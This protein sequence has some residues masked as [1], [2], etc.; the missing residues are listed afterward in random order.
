MSKRTETAPKW[1]PSAGLF[2]VGGLMIVAAVFASLPASTRGALI[3]F[4][5]GLAL[6]GAVLPRIYGETELTAKGFRTQ[7]SEAVANSANQTML[8]GEQLD[9]LYGQILRTLPDTALQDPEESGRIVGRQV[10]ESL[11]Q[12]GQRIDARLDAM[13]RRII[14]ENPDRDIADLVQPLMTAAKGIG[15]EFT[16]AGAEQTLRRAEDEI[17]NS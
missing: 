1:I 15:V 9:R 11:L 4:G 16:P 5:S 8:T 10:N 6:F 3:L 17:R 2:V 14:E 7:I 12:F 13:A